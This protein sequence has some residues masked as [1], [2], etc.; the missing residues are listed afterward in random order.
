MIKVFKRCK[1]NFWEPGN[2]GL[3]R[4]LINIF[5]KNW[6]EKVGDWIRYAC[7]VQNFW[8]PAAAYYKIMSTSAK[9]QDCFFY[10]F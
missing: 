9:Q 2:V 8:L 4:L 7:R 1:G 10:L 3:S 5:R 6:Y